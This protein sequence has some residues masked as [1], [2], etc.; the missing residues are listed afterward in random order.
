MTGD[1]KQSVIDR[2]TAYKKRFDDLLA[3][4]QNLPLERNDKT[5]AQQ[6][7]KTLKDS[8]ENDYRAGDTNRGQQRMTEA[9]RRYF[10]PT[11]HQAYAEIHVRWN[12]VP[13]DQWFSQ[14]YGAQINI[15]HM[16]HEL[17]G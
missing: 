2:L 1:E 17:E 5:R 7:L 15:T 9:E 3:L 16:L 12:T 11:V 14:V 8:L 6:M 10:H 13:N 4:L